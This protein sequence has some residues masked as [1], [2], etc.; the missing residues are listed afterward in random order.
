MWIS[1]EEFENL[2]AQAAGS[3]KDLE[4]KINE[5]YKVINLRNEE[6]EEKERL[7]F[8]QIN[9]KDRAYESDK[10][11]INLQWQRKLDLANS[12]TDVEVMKATA[13]LNKSLAAAE[14]A[15]DVALGEN[16][17]MREAFKSM[18]ID[19]KDMKDMFGKLVD[20]ISSKN[21][22]NLITSGK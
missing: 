19:V 22:V 9:E 21:Q 7:Y 18:G 2:K 11:H 5:L 13:S 10:E 4:Q 15:R 12:K 8:R 14:T 16:K 6:I 3:N 17:V 20:G 1:K